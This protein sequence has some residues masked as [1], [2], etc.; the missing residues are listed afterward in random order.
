VRTNYPYIA[1]LSETNAFAHHQT[2][3]H[4][5]RTNKPTSQSYAKTTFS[6]SHCPITELPPL[7]PPT[8]PN[9]SSPL[10]MTHQPNRPKSQNSIPK[11]RGINTRIYSMMKRIS[12]NTPSTTSPPH[13]PSARKSISRSTSARSVSLPPR[14]VKTR[15]ETR[16]NHKPWCSC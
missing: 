11:R 10:K 5:L 12:T 16:S 4:G 2:K 15:M 3:H 6:T 14:P 9:A 7:R 1:A 13:P 8:E